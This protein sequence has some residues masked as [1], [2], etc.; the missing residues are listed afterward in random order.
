MTEVLEA[1]TT[2]VSGIA[3]G[4]RHENV[5]SP[6]TAD[7]SREVPLCGHAACLVDTVRIHVGYA[8]CG[9]LIDAYQCLTELDA[10]HCEWPSLL[11]SDE[12]V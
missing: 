5:T 7:N 12:R 3:H 8:F 2:I 4:G 10:G 11:F 9:L 6:M 1:L